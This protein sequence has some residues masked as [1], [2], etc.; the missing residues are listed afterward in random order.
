MGINAYGLFSQMQ[1]DTVY[2]GRSYELRRQLDV[3]KEQLDT[4]NSRDTLSTDQLKKRDQLQ[5][6]VNHLQSSLSKYESG[7]GPDGKANSVTYKNPGHY[8]G[9]ATTPQD[10]YLKGFFVDI[11]L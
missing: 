8:D 4:L 1:S 10:T 2:S 7:S 6:A 5:S 9:N 11:R 3:R